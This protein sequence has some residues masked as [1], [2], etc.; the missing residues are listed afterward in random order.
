MNNIILKITILVAVFSIIFP[1]LFGL[2]R[3]VKRG[4]GF[5]IGLSFFCLLWIAVLVCGLN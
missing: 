4:G 2:V 5:F 1:V 3:P